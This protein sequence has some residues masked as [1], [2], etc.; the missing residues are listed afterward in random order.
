MY[1]YITDTNSLI[2]MLFWDKVAFP[3]GQLFMHVIQ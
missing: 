3:T 1:R 2:G